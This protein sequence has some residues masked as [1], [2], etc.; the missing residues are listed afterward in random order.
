MDVS[1]LN[2]VKF[3]IYI[4]NVITNK[5]VR[6]SKENNYLTIPSRFDF[7][8]FKDVLYWSIIDIETFKRREQNIKY[9]QNYINNTTL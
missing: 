2:K 6:F 8:N 3:N 9:T 1:K 7:E 5:R 4:N